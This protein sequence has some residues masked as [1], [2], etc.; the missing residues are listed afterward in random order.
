MIVLIGFITGFLMC[1]PFGPINVLVIMTALKKNYWGSLSIGLGSSVMDFIYFLII[2]NGIHFVTL[3][4]VVLQVGQIFGICLLFG[5]GTKELLSKPKFIQDDKIK[6]KTQIT[7]NISL[8]IVMYVSNPTY[9]VT[10]TSLVVFI[11]TQNWF[12]EN[13]FNFTLVSLGTALGSGFW[14]GFI[15][16]LI[17]KYENKFTQ[18][19]VSR[20][21][22]ICGALI[23]GLAFLFSYK[24]LISIF[25]IF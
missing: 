10:L 24:F 5:L 8:G 13:I 21:N 23:M 25:K 6:V 3:S 14:F 2:F 16:L 4:P 19:I 18:K 9:W 15:I 11:K 17:K 20:I 12:P 1:I 22:L 7:K